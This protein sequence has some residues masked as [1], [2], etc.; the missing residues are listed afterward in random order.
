[1]LIKLLSIIDDEVNLIIK[2]TFDNENCIIVLNK[3]KRFLFD[4]NRKLTFKEIMK[5]INPIL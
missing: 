5:I 2:R 4:P 3:Q 1:M